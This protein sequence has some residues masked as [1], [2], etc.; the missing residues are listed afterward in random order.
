MPN[1]MWLIEDEVE[2]LVKILSVQ[3]GKYS[4]EQM[5]VALI[6]EKTP[7]KTATRVVNRIYGKKS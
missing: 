7:A 1:L 4:K 2:K 3:K 5:C 6:Q